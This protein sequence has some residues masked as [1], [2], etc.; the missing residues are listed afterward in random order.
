MAFDEGKFR[1][2]VLTTLRIAPQQYRP[3]L[4]LGEIEEWDSVAHLDLVFALE[5]AFGR[6]LDPDEMVDLTGLADL[7]A[8]FMQPA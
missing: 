6:K 4:R 3:D 8:R 7:R 2:T 1:E 5:Q